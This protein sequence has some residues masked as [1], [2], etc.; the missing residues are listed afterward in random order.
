MSRIEWRA[1]ANKQEPVAVKLGIRGKGRVEV[2]PVDK[3]ETS[4]GMQS[5]VLMIASPGQGH[6]APL[7]KFA[8]RIANNGIKVTFVNSDFI[9]GKVVAALPDEGA[10]RGRIRLVSIPDGLDPGEVG[11]DIAKLMESIERV[12]PGHFK[13]LIEKVNRSNDN[14]QITCVI[15]DIILGRWPMEVAEKMGIQWVPF[16]PFGP[17]ILALLLHIPKLIE[18]R[19]VNSTDGRY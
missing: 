12:M 15:A 8:H 18:A 4:M 2:L 9:H 5:H 11:R 6:V 3:L 10:D 7:M 19:I 1:Q 14:E 16:C 13:D 17:G